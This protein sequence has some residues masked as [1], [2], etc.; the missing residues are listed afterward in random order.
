MKITIKDKE[1]EL[2]FNYK[3]F[4]ILATLLGLNGVQA[5]FNSFNDLGGNE[6]DVFASLICASVISA[7]NDTVTVDDAGD[8]ILQNQNRI[9]ELTEALT[10][11]LPKPEPEAPGNDPAL[12]ETEAQ[13]IS[14]NP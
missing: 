4:R 14:Q 8:W 5:V 7:G 12:T 6:I 9:P 11:S 2:V 13:L 10:T 1:C 3:T